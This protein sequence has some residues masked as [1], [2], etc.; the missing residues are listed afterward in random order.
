MSCRNGYA[1]YSN[2]S[3]GGG[4]FPILGSPEDEYKVAQEN[5]FALGDN[6][7]NSS[8]SRYFGPVP[9]Q[10][11]VGRGLVVY[12]PFLGQWGLIR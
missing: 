12:W 7:Y 11:V 5:Y 3:A 4:T 6:S 10:N 1:G 2:G 8:D 9:Q